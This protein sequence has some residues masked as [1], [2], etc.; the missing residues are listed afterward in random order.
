[1][2]WVFSAEVDAIAFIFPVLLSLCYV[3]P[4]YK[5]VK[6]ASTASKTIIDISINSSH[7]YG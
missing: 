7:K 1:M 3:P 6:L 5:E 2:A 4:Y